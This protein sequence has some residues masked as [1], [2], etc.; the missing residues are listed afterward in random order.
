MHDMSRHKNNIK[1]VNFLVVLNY[2]TERIQNNK[3][4]E[5]CINITGFIFNAGISCSAK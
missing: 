5:R 1:M 4:K 3:K 2:S